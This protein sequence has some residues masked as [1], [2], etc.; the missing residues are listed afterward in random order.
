[1]QTEVDGAVV[2]EIL[3]DDNSEEPL[4]TESHDL[5]PGLESTPTG[6]GSG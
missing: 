2:E 6:D 1:M 3:A 5:Q 4:H